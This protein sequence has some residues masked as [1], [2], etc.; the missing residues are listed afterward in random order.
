MTDEKLCLQW[1]DFQNNI[2][3]AFRDMRNDEHFTDVTLVCEDGPQIDAHK[4]VLVAC[5]PFFKNILQKNKHTHPI[6]Y[7]KGVQSKELVAIRDFL[8]QGEANVHQEDLNSFLALA[9]ELQLK[10]LQANDQQTKENISENF[11]P[12]NFARKPNFSP[13]RLRFAEEK[14]SKLPNK[15]ISNQSMETS[16]NNERALSLNTDSYF[17]NEKELAEKVKSLMLVSEN[18]SK[19][20]PGVGRLRICKVCGKEG[21]FQNMTS[22]IEANHIS[23]IVIP[24]NI[25]GIPKAS[26][27]GLA[28]HKLKFHKQ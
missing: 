27:N 1:N 19:T 9:E 24:C 5:S 14:S 22:H 2:S 16:P 10:G 23:G 17:T 18:R 15:T 7:M 11:E 6:I 28:Q 3:S 12:K 8:Y 4:V 20:N 26:R 13:E 25:C 21:Q